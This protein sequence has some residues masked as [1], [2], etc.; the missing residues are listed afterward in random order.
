MKKYKKNILLFIVLLFISFYYLFFKDML[1]TERFS[2]NNIKSCNIRSFRMSTN[3]SNYK[4]NQVAT[5]LENV[6]MNIASNQGNGYIPDNNIDCTK[7]ICYIGRNNRPNAGLKECKNCDNRLTKL[8]SILKCLTY[9]HNS[10]KQINGSGKELDKEEDK[11][12][13]E[14]EIIDESNDENSVSNNLKTGRFGIIL[15]TDLG[16]IEYIIMNKDII[17]KG[18]IKAMGGNSKDVSSNLNDILN[19]LGGK[20]KEIIDVWE[21]LVETNNSGQDKNE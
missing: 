20:K 12:K 2:G 15:P 1:N 7:A 10:L 17:S 8:T 16:N 4:I 18:I 9:F 5:K 11:D 19:E 13:K 21:K 14:D 6:V 3:S